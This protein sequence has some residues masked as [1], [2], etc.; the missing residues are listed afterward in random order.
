MGLDIQWGTLQPVDIGGAF[1]QGMEQGRQRR[2]E[3]ETQKGLAAYAADPT[4][5]DPINA[6][7]RYNPAVAFQLQQHQQATADRSRG[8]QYRNA[9]A[10]YHGLGAYQGP[11]PGNAASMAPQVPPPAPGQSALAGVMPAPPPGADPGWG[12]NSDPMATMGDPSAPP[13]PGGQPQQSPQQ[14]PQPAQDQRAAGRD[15]AWQRML[16]ADPEK[17][18]AMRKAEQADL[19]ERFEHADDAYG[20]AIRSLSS[21]T[22]EA[23]YQRIRKGFMAR[24][25]P[26]GIDI[27]GQIPPNYPGPEGIDQLLMSA[28]DAK[29]QLAEERARQ[30]AEWDQQDDELDNQRED[31]KADSLVS[32]R[33]DRASVARDR[34]TRLGRGERPRGSRRGKG[35][36]AAAGRDRPGWA[37]NQETKQWLR[38]NGSTWVPTE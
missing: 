16:A 20:Y 8:E 35:G 3:A 30:K 24:V 2:V 37:Y 7:M 15:R 34:E 22:D 9:L 36:S 1:Q 27:E 32:W 29:E 4:A 17:A 13:A 25:A 10:A 12:W 33:Q 28:L 14:Q 6:L 5:S 19:W 31:R 26:L 21:A 23:S 38:W 18:I 11:V